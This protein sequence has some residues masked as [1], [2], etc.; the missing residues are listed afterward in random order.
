MSTFI[1][2]LGIEVW[3]FVVSGWTV[4][5]KIQN[6]EIMIKPNLEWNCEERKA[7]LRNFIAL[8]A[9]QSGMDDKTF[10]LIASSESAKEA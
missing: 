5:T 6:G 10:R 4:L 7:V 9:I 2:S 1:K 3:E 8:H